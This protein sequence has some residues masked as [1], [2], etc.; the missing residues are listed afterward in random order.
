LDKTVV[1]LVGGFFYSMV[2]IPCFFH[3]TSVEAGE[4]TENGHKLFNS[5]SVLVKGGIKQIVDISGANSHNGVEEH[6]LVMEGRSE[7]FG[8]SVERV[9]FPISSDVPDS[10][11]ECG[12]DRNYSASNDIPQPNFIHSWW[13]PLLV[14]AQT[15]FWFVIFCEAARVRR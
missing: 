13:F 7:L 8:G 4:V 6:Q 11:E 9:D 10:G 2:F 5:G 14:G 15:F 3:P 12:S 1:V